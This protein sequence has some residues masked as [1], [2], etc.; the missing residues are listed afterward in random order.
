[1]VLWGWMT[2]DRKLGGMEVWKRG[3]DT[4]VN[5]LIIVFGERAA[6]V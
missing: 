5:M 3:T 2:V 4:V 1:M 6:L